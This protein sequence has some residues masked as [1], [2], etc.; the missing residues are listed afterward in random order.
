MNNISIQI[1]DLQGARCFTI[2]NHDE[3]RVILKVRIY[4][5]KTT[6]YQISVDIDEEYNEQQK[7]FLNRP[8]TRQSSL[9]IIAPYIE[10][11][12][13]LEQ[14]IDLIQKIDP[15]PVHVFDELNHFGVFLPNYCLDPI[16]KASLNQHEMAI[17][18]ALRADK[19]DLPEK[20]AELADYYENTANI[21]R[22]L[23]L[24]SKVPSSSACFQLVNEKLF[25]Y[26]QELP[27]THTTLAEKFKCAYNAGLTE[28]AERLFTEL[29]G[30]KSLTALI[31]LPL[32][33]DPEFLI[34]MA[35]I[36]HSKNE[37]INH[38][39]G[40]ISEIVETPSLISPVNKL[41]IFQSPGKAQDTLLPGSDLTL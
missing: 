28:I 3:G 9:G 40:E 2:N 41:S 31:P 36:I 1:I 12:A 21:A 18:E 33:Y 32:G 6:G 38:K 4:T 14:Y 11:I 27:I 37:Q 15:L 19:E 25:D 26:Y 24:L 17:E 30:E 16:L 22:W 20:F 5:F 34:Q 39:K 23:E 13:L 7:K 29:A 10:T 35:M 8:G